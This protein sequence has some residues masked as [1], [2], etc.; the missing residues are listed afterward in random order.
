M[1]CRVPTCNQ[2][3]AMILPGTAAE[4]Q[5]VYAELCATCRNR[6]RVMARYN[7]CT[8]DVAAERIIASEG[9]RAIDPIIQVIDRECERIRDAMARAAAP[10]EGIVS[11]ELA[12]QRERIARACEDVASDHVVNSDCH[13]TAM[14]CARAAR[15]VP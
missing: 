7:A 2:E 11:A 13:R 15:C 5:P 14:A 8:E 12:A 4:Y 9:L 6:A 3:A 10:A 1:M